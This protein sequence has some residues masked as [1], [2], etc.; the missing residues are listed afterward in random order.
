ME[1]DIISPESIGIPFRRMEALTLS[2]M[3][4]KDKNRRGVYCWKPAIANQT[5]IW[6]LVSGV[7]TQHARQCPPH[8]ITIQEN[9]T[10]AGYYTANN[11]L[12]YV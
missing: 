3:F 10:K 5:N 8:L 9:K 7:F 12:L 1:V 4:V 2:K 6:S 11:N